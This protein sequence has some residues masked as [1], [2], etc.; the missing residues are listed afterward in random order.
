M[1]LE[2]SNGQ[3]PGGP[4]LFVRNGLK[5]WAMGKERLARYSLA[6]PENQAAVDGRAGGRRLVPQRRS[7]AS[8]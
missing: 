8:G 5:G 3:E 7:R 6:G 2:R 4:P 1:L